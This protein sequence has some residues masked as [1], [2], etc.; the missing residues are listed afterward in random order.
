[1]KLGKGAAKAAELDGSRLASADALRREFPT[2]VFTPDRLAVVK[3]GPAVRRA[4]LDRVLGRLLPAR[5]GTAAATT[6]PRSRSGTPRCDASSSAS[7]PASALAPWTRPPRRAGG[8]ARRGPAG[9]GRSSSSPP[10]ASGSTQLGLAGGALRLR[11]R[12]ADAQ[13]TSRRGSRPTSRAGT[14]GLGPASRRPCDQRRAAA[15]CGASARRAS[16][17]SRC[18]RC[19]SRRRA[20]LPAEPAAPARRRALRARRAPPR[21]SSPSCVAGLGQTVITTTHRSALPVEPS[22]VVEVTP[23]TAL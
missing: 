4:Y 21:R 2:L 16:S 22:Q 10:F 19:C 3:G 23:G 20:L 7:R 11:G 18:S 1:M 9:D 13:P 12:A 5:A 14:T 17:G 6:R 15:S 8:R